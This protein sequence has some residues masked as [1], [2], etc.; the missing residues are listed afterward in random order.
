MSTTT[1]PTPVLGTPEEGILAMSREESQTELHEGPDLRFP[2]RTIITMI[3][4]GRIYQASYRSQSGKVIA[5][6]TIGAAALGVLE[7]DPREG[8]RK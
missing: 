6:K 1:K 8:G 7:A 5:L 3:H 2:G 4:R